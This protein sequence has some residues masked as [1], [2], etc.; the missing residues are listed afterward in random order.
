MTMPAIIVLTQSGLAVAGLVRAALGGAEIHGLAG[1]V[2]GA[3]R[4][5]D[6]VSVLVQ[7]LF[8][9]GV[10]VI[11]VCAAGILVRAVAPVLG[12]KRV[13]PPVL[14]VAEDTSCV[15]P[16]IGGHHGGN[17]MAWRIAAALQAQAAI[18]TASD[19]RFG[20]ALDDPPPGW[21]VAN[22]AAVKPVAAALL[23]DEPVALRVESGD[24]AWLRGTGAR[25]AD[26]GDHGV[27]V[28]DGANP[29]DARQLVLHPATLVVGIGSERGADPHIAV[30]LAR[31]ALAEAELS[32]LSVA[33]VASI[34]LKMD[35][36]AVHA[37]AEALGV[38]ARFFDAAALER[39]TPRL[40]NPSR[41]VF[42][43]VGC[44]G[45][46]EGAALAGV[47]GDGLL[48]V[49]K[50]KDRGVT[51]AVGRAPRVLDP[52]SVGQARGR[53]AVI[54]I[55][56]GDAAWRT[57]E[58]AAELRRATDLVG[59][60]RYL[61]LVSEAEAGGDRHAFGLG[62]ETARC[63]AALD[64]A[65]AGREVALVCSGDAG[66]YAMAA[67]VFEL[68]DRAGRADWRRVDTRVVPG[69]SALQAAAARAGAPLG[70]DFCAVSLSDL[71]TPWSVIERRL[72]AA[73]TADFVTAIYNPRSA[74]RQWQL[75]R[76]LEILT[77]ARPPETPVVVA[78]NLG[79]NDETIDITALSAVE[80]T[81]IDMLTVL[82]V[83]AA[84][85]RRFDR[86]AGGEW[87]YTARGYNSTPA[88][89]G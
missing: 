40:A 76:A 41:Q 53:L 14:A 9:E 54:G 61:D 7:A 55:G 57:A 30:E 79:R 72:Q 45:V 37:V 12:D 43:T 89:D 80:P 74:D 83:G 78:R 36:P 38:P 82:I 31:R 25:F 70:H 42:L 22:P 48:A 20:L 67:L 27:V 32:P 63:R 16:L 51:C 5:Y 65:A 18:T 58:A 11:G 6:S 44:H 69:L 47:G 75:P 33:C 87:V 29:G 60:S 56:P 59:Y 17:D 10:P 3:D 77:A 21:R 84:G 62:D 28:T 8:A 19:V 50:R 52:A 26:H 24:A 23:A 86:G 15:V 64:L 81:D 66:I 46:A 73:A 13:E 49:E 35:E 4:S 71:L 1:R 34:D 85:S 68:I 88:N 2:D 39:E